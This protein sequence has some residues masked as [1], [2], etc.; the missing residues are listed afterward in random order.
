MIIPTSTLSLWSPLQPS[1][2][3]LSQHPDQ[4]CLSFSLFYLFTCQILSLF[5]C[6]HPEIPY[7]ITPAPASMRLL[8]QTIYPLLP[9][10]SSTILGWIIEHSP[11]QNHEAPLPLMADKVIL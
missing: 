5:P 3:S 8:P 4:V 11:M 1:N 9:H 7:P 2:M 10:P 6:S